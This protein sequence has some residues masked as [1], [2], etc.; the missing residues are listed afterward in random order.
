MKARVTLC[1]GGLLAVAAALNWA[2]VDAVAPGM[3]SRA[4][5][6]SMSAAV[7]ATLLAL[8]L[9]ARLEAGIKRIAAGLTE[10]GRGRRDLR[11][12]VE[13]EPLVAFLAKAANEA[14]MAMADTNDPAVGAVRVRKR[15]ET[16]REEPAA[17]T[18]DVESSSAVKAAAR[19]GATPAAEQA[20]AS[21]EPSAPL[22]EPRLDEE[23]PPLS[24]ATRTTA[25]ESPAPLV[26]PAT[27]PSSVPFMA[28]AVPA[29]AALTPLP[30]AASMT[31]AQARQQHFKVVFEEYCAALKR[32]GEPMGE[33]T[34]EGFSATLSATEKSLVEQHGCRAVRFSVL[35]ENG[36]VQLLPR[37]V[38]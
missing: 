34:S 36:T 5:W 28:A 6:V 3:G 18:D 21:S 4:L 27:H 9:T 32:V 12:D 20:V 10:V 11:F 13:R 23:L 8:W 29:P 30:R 17:K 19:P 15:K 22:D 1:V 2:V 14:L 16:H 38:R 24:P 25:E 35:V 26:P 31:D 7:A 37:L 33:L